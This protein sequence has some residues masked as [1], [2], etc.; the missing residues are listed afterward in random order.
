M[1]TWHRIQWR[2]NDPAEERPRW[3]RV[4][5]IN[6]VQS[7]V[8]RCGVAIPEYPYMADYDDDIA[9]QARICKRCEGKR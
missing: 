6:S 7:N 2:L 3:T 4:H 5:L 8:A 9:P 1:D